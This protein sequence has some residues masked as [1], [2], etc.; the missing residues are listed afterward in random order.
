MT[1]DMTDERA[2]GEERGRPVAQEVNTARLMNNYGPPPVVFVRG[3]GAELWDDSGKHYLDFLCGIAVTSLGHSHP[4][5]SDAI[6]T[7]AGKLTHVSN[8]FG[9]EPT[10]EVVQTLDRLIR[11][12]K[13]GK[14][15]DGGD[16]SETEAGHSEPGRL[17]FQNSGAETIEAAIKLVR[18]HHGRGRHTI[19]SAHDSFHGRTL[20][21]LA[22]TGQP[23]KH[24]PFQP[25]PEGFRYVA[26]NDIDALEAVLDASVG[27]VLLETVQG[28][29]G[30]HPADLDYLV[31]VRELCDE[32]GVLL[33]MDEIQTGM[34]RTGRWFGYQH[35]DIQPDVVA[36]AKAL[37][38]GMPVG[39]MWA[40][41]EIAAAF[42]PGDHGSTFAGQPLALAAVRAVLD[43]MIRIDAPAVARRLG[44]YL[45]GLLEG[46]EGVDHVRGR[47]LL[48]GVE[49]TEDALAG[50]TAK[51]VA[52]E[53]LRRG[54]VLNNVT[55]TALRLAPPLIATEEQLADGV[56]IIDSV[57]KSTAP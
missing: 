17:L 38:N 28:E 3:A 8:L 53:C 12:G 54:L 7:Q 21:A 40:R 49:I 56:T 52:A 31:A 50:R 55:K 41:P 34:A 2:I 19:V 10:A 15:G 20:G 39:A 44:T 25:L 5:V 9:N 51:E 1:N 27:G 22:A 36:M 6:S 35:A 33:V 42:T 18:K 23:K 45:T 47:G 57:L 37:G 29:G 43:T 16:G 13:D 46:L 24:E 4:V 30:V 26:F 11:H 32:R 14:H 48:L